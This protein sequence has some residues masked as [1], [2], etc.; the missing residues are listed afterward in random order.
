MFLKQCILLGIW[1]NLLSSLRR[2]VLNTFS[3]TWLI[4]CQSIYHIFILFC[5]LSRFEGV[6]ARCCE[7]LWSHFL[8]KQVCGTV[9]INVPSSFLAV[10]FNI[11]FNN[12]PMA[13]QWAYVIVKRGVCQTDRRANGNPHKRFKLNTN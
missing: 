13:S 1:E 4:T 12:F 2:Y 7:R 3:I 11:D 9:C 6:F 10:N 8:C 5:L